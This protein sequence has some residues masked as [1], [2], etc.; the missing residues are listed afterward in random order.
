MSARSKTPDA[1]HADESTVRLT[2]RMQ[3]DTTISSYEVLIPMKEFTEMGT[4]ELAQGYAVPV[5]EVTCDK[6][7]EASVQRMMVEN[8]MP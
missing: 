8:F 1:G 5:F 3:W 6:L 2:V 7:K 4:A